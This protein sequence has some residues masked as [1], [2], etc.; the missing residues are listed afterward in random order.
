M[1]EPASPSLPPIL[2]RK[3]WL[4]LLVALTLLIGCGLV[5]LRPAWRATQ[6]REASNTQLI[7]ALKADTHNS[8]LWTVLGARL[9]QTG[10]YAQASWSLHNALENGSKDPL[11][12]TAEAFTLALAG[13]PAQARQVLQQGAQE[14]IPG[15]D[16]TLEQV[17]QLPGTTPPDTLASAISPEGATPLLNSATAGSFLNGIV[18]WWGRGHPES[19]GVA[20]REAWAHDAPNNATAQRWWGEALYHN[21]ALAQALQVLNYAVVLAPDS[22]PTRVLLAKTLAKAGQPAKAIEQYQICLKQHADDLPALLGLSEMELQQGQIGAPVR[23]YERAT[24]LD[25]QSADAWVGL[26]RADMKWTASG[27][28]AL[29]AFDHA[30]RLAPQRTDFFDDYAEALRA[31]YQF[32]DAESLLRRRL[33]AVSDD[34]R[35]HYLLG[36]LLARN[37]PDAQRRKAAEVELRLVL[38][39]VPGQ[40]LAEVE[41]AQLYLRQFQPQAA[42]PLLRQ[43]L[44]QDSLDLTAPRLLAEALRQMGKLDEARMASERADK[45][46]QLVAQLQVMRHLP[47]GLPANA[48]KYRQLATLY[49]SVGMTAKARAALRQANQTVQNQTGQWAMGKTNSAPP[50]AVVENSER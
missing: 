4:W 12:W 36:S 47:P 19:S 27:E 3:R 17:R 24:K 13:R 9:A 6:L 10:L 45:I 15:V 33:Q 25:P 7:E 40:P 49:A 44:A 1:S 38:K 18:A 21:Q 11:C 41:L 29:A 26:G 43:V 50:S 30:T 46:T 22:A 28:D 32:D 35:A 16:K 42:L 31:R 5:V 48:K 37:N 23:G 14:G 20:T 34:A 39:E 8:Q 2:K